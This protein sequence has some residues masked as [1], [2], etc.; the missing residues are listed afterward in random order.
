MQEHCVSRLEKC[1]VWTKSQ[2]DNVIQQ[3]Q[4]SV[5]EKHAKSPDDLRKQKMAKQ[6]IEYLQ[7]YKEVDMHH[8]YYE[9]ILYHRPA[10][11]IDT[12]DVKTS[13]DALQQR[14][15]IKCSNPT[16]LIRAK[17]VWQCYKCGFRQ[18]FISAQTNVTIVPIHSDKDIDEIMGGSGS[19]SYIDSDGKHLSDTVAGSK[20]KTNTDVPKWC[21]AIVRRIDNSCRHDTLVSGDPSLWNEFLGLLL[22]YQKERTKVSLSNT[23]ET[24]CSNNPRFTSWN[25][26]SIRRWIMKK[27]DPTPPM[28][29]TF[30]DWSWMKQS[31]LKW[32]RL[33]E[34]F[35]RI[36]AEFV[37]HYLCLCK[38][39]IGRAQYV[40]CKYTANEFTT[41]VRFLST[42]ANRAQLSKYWS[43]EEIC[44][45]QIIPSVSLN[46]WKKHLFLTKK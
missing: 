2:T 7:T 45:Q 13:I 27:L 3:I 14:K 12:G 1:N 37:F 43:K 35:T 34:S 46:E 41:Y 39:W 32:S 23:I 15:C 40:N 10:E 6:M 19:D 42:D 18:C 29:W 4:T 9:H 28:Q 21:S 11:F 24:I 8:P 22:A 16:S 25:K 31:L 33:G 30:V 44:W 38:R 17:S 20:K 36:K 5:I 26:M